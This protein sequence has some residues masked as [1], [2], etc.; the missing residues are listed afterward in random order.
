MIVLWFLLPIVFMSLGTS[1]LYH[2]A[3][4]FL[5]PVA[6]AGG[7]AVARL[8]EGLWRISDRLAGVLSSARPGWS[9]RSAVRGVASAFGLLALIIAIATEL[10]GRV[11]IA[12]GDTV[13]LRNDSVVRPALLWLGAWIVGA[14]KY[15]LQSILPVAVLVMALPGDE[16]RSILQRSKTIDRPVHDVAACLS[17]V[18]RERAQ[19]RKLPGVL[20]EEAASSHRYSYYLHDLGPWNSHVSVSDESIATH[21]YTQTSYA[22]VLLTQ[23]RVGRFQT[24]M[25]A[26]RETRVGAFEHDGTVLLLPGPYAVCAP[27]R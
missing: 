7:Y 13:L 2:Y 15:L 14:P 3:Y 17:T 23:G 27:A 21:L 8:L 24:A 9:N 4:P 16:Y 6:I 1:K 18:A 12:I 19:W 20:V 25:R 10:F 22:P 5:P 26:E 11:R